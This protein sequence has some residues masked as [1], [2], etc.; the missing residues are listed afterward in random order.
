MLYR[1]RQQ[2]LATSFAFAISSC[3]YFRSNSFRRGALTVIRY[4]ISNNCGSYQIAKY[5]SLGTEQF[6]S[7]RS[8]QRKSNSFAQRLL[9]SF[10]QLLRFRSNLE[11]HIAC[12]EAIALIG[13]AYRYN[14]A[15]KQLNPSQMLLQNSFS[16]SECNLYHTCARKS[17]LALA[18]AKIVLQGNCSGVTSFACWVVLLLKQRYFAIRLLKRTTS[19]LIFD[20]FHSSSAEMLWTSHTIQTTT[21]SASCELRP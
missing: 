17:F 19:N 3:Q 2:R 9:F 10:Q 16:L 4:V 14:K 13:R 11:N 12:S 5:S 1:K 20:S 15:G 21:Q 6:N 18:L 8:L 7:F